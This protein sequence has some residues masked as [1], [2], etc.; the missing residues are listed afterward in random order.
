M[1]KP[2]GTTVGGERELAQLEA[3]P[4]SLFEE[5]RQRARLVLSPTSLSEDVAL[6]LVFESS[7]EREGGAKGHGP[8]Q[9]NVCGPAIHV[10]PGQSSAHTDTPSPHALSAGLVAGDARLECQEVARAGTTGP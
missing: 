1:N 3:S 5:P 9:G 8:A 10:L 4:I 6:V 2:T 7:G